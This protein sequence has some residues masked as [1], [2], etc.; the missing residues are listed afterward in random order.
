[1]TAWLVA[2]DPYGLIR[3]D[4]IVSVSAVP[5]NDRGDSRWDERHP[6]RQMREARRVHVMVASPGGVA[7]VLTCPGVSVQEAIAQLVALIENP[8]G[9][10]EKRILYVC[11]H[12]RSWG[13]NA[14][15]WRVSDALPDPD[16]PAVR[17]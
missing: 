11:G 7:R 2:E 15:I 6:D 14:Q 5:L 1:M 16:W 13:G 12:R 4:R 10:D 17:V 3:L 9:A 8:P